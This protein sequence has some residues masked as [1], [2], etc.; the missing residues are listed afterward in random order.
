MTDPE[1]PWDAMHLCSLFLPEKEFMPTSTTTHD[2][3]AID[4]KY[5]LPPRK[6]DWFKNTIPTPNAFEEGNMPNISPTVKVNIS[7][8]SEKV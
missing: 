3:C 6:V 1:F 2:I 8:K 4:S 5:F 7:N